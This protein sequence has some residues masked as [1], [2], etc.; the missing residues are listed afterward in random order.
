M[1]LALGSLHRVEVWSAA[2]ILEMHVVSIFSVYA[3]KVV[4]L[5]IPHSAKPII[6]IKIKSYGMIISNKFL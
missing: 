6:K 4:I 1:Y 3:H 2:E 5:S